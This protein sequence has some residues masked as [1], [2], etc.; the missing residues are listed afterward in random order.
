MMLAM[1]MAVRLSIRSRGWVLSCGGVVWRRLAG[2]QEAVRM[3]PLWRNACVGG[4]T[5]CV[6]LWMAVVVGGVN[7]LPWLLLMVILVGML[8]KKKQKHYPKNYINSRKNRMLWP[9]E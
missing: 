1:P 9:Q 3:R 5:V 6:P 2:G 8:R 4:W 7:S